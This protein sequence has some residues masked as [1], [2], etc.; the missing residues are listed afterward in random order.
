[1]NQ[2]TIALNDGQHIPQ[3]GLGVWQVPD[4]ITAKVV[5]EALAAGYRSIDT[6]RIYDNE[7]S[8]GA[9]LA[10]SG[11]PRHELFITTKLWNSAHGY[12]AAL[13]GFDASLRRLGLDYVD[14]Y[15]IHWP[16]PRKNLYVETWRALIELHKQGRARSIGV[17]NFHIPYLQRILD[18]TGVVPVLNQIELHP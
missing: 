7:S 15:L 16:A 18:E 4:D 6:A 14:L 13:R 11:L 10:A 3:L 12:D 5:T 8:V 17:S 2:P 1:M 9:A